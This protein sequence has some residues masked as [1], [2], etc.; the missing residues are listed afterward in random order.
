MLPTITC[1]MTEAGCPRAV[2]ISKS[3]VQHCTPGLQSLT[4]APSDCISAEAWGLPQL[5]PPTASLPNP[6]HKVTVKH[7]QGFGVTLAHLSSLQILSLPHP[8]VHVTCYC[9]RRNNYSDASTPCANGPCTLGRSPCAL[10]SAPA[11][12]HGCTAQGPSQ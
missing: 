10:A 9:L 1:H 5:Y 8:S 3:Q 7:S 2:I 4:A 11:D 6:S 12:T